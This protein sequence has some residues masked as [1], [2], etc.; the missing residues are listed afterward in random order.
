M[1]LLVNDCDDASFSAPRHT[2]N[3]CNLPL[4]FDVHLWLAFNTSGSK[5]TKGVHA[6]DAAFFDSVKCVIPKEYVARIGGSF[7]DDALGFIGPQLR[8]MDRTPERDRLNHD[9]SF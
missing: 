9:V 1:A 7:P 2:F 3:D 8:P 4:S 5:N 6:R